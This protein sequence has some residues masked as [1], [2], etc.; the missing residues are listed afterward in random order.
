MNGPRID[1]YFKV[2]CGASQ[3]NIHKV[4][5][6]KEYLK[7]GVKHA[8]KL[9]QYIWKLHILFCVSILGVTIVIRIMN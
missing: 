4:R 7:G 3:C 6:R 8:M 9:S 2:A 1:S 5:A